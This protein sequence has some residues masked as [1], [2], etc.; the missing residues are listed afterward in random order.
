M[1]NRHVGHPAVAVEADVADRLRR[2]SLQRR[3]LSARRGWSILRRQAKPP[4]DLR[5]FPW[6]AESSL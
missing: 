5:E 3:R 6:I 1:Q 2:R 4:T